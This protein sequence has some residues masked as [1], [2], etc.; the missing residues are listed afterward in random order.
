[1][2][3]RRR[4]LILRYLALLL[5]LVVTI[6]PLLWQLSSSLK[7]RTEP[8]FG[9]GATLLPRHPTLSA[10]TTVFDQ[11]PMALY[12]RNS[13]I[14]CAL[15]VGG[16]LVLPTLAGYMLSRP[17]WR[18]ARLTYVLLV[19]SMMFPFESIM[20]SLYLMVQGMGLVDSLAGVWLPGAVSAVDVFLMRAAFSAVPTEVEEAA[21]L[22]GATEWQRF[23]RIY[24]PASVGA[25]TV[26]AINSFISAWDDFLWPFVVLRSE[27]HFTL[28]LGLSR[29]AQSQLGFDPRVIMAGSMIAILPIVGLFVLCQRW[30][31]RG[32]AEGAVK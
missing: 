1:M 31:F 29:L 21:L 23:R 7:S 14:V 28:S 5:V 20:V 17:G 27:S 25:L 12:V 19:L 24:L 22:D 3:Y 32:V 26:V 30:F 6:G 2:S 8:V 10:Y 18:G 11:V 9:D 15:S 16:Q 13:L 4:A